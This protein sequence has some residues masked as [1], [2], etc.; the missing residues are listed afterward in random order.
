MTTIITTLAYDKTRDSEVISGNLPQCDVQRKETHMRSLT[1][2][3]E[4]GWAADDTNTTNKQ[5]Q[6]QQTD[7]LKTWESGTLRCDCTE[8]WCTL[9]AGEGHSRQPSFPLPLVRPRPDR[10]RSLITHYHRFIS[11]ITA[12]GVFYAN[13]LLGHASTPFI[14]LV[15]HNLRLVLIK[16][17]TYSYSPKTSLEVTSHSD[18]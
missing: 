13:Y 4:I 14:T 10:T 3:R 17:C 6:I 16:T 12:H 18:L 2:G 9:N 8:G 5:Q 15:L 11:I 1:E 7:E